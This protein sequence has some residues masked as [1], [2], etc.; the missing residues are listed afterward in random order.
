MKKIAALF[1]TMT[2]VA[3]SIAQ[4]TSVEAKT[5]K[6]NAFSVRVHE[7]KKLTIQNVK[8]R[9]TW[10]KLSGKNTIRLTKSGKYSV[11]IQGK[12]KGTARLQAKIGK[13]KVVYKITVKAAKKSVSKEPSQKTEVTPMPTQTSAP[14]DT[15]QTLENYE[16][17]VLRL[18]N[19]ERAKQGLSALKTE[20]KL[21]QAATIRAKELPT[22]FSHTRPDGQ[23]CFSVLEEI[24]I[25]TYRSCGENIAAG[26]ETPKEV[27]D[28]W[29]N[30]PGHRANIL[31]EKYTYMGLGICKTTGG[32][33]YYWA[34]MF[35]S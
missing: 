28:G 2:L 6:K 24:G 11:L 16:S 23:S 1:L 21:S 19:E 17:E 15:P 22:L 20:T 18:V 26:Y 7:T 12:K 9:V 3:G 25:S 35:M 4:P 14:T 32:M 31:S 10:K 8:K 34:Q 33:E 29:M 13:K 5:L 27:V 30:S